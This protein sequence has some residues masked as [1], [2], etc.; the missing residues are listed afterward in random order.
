M[1]QDAPAPTG[2]TRPALQRP[3]GHGEARRR[4][5]FSY[6]PL[7]F[8]APVNPKPRRKR[9]P[10]AVHRRRLAIQQTLS[11]TGDQ[12]AREYVLQP[13]TPKEK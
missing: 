10:T 6:T 1:P 9:R 8:P 5:S 11:F 2:T 3:P 12:V 7:L 4:A 13:P